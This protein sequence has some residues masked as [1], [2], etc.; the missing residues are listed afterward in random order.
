MS[1][2]FAGVPG[3][4]MGPRILLEGTSALKQALTIAKPFVPGTEAGLRLRGL[5][6]H[7]PEDGG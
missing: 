1:R 4:L 6:P 7:R 2:R 5:G 3:G